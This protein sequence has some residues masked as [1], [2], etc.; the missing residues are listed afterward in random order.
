[1]TRRSGVAEVGLLAAAVLEGDLAAERG[2]QAEDDENLGA[3]I[4]GAPN[5]RRI[6]RPVLVDAHLHDTRDEA[7]EKSDV[8]V[9]APKECVMYLD[10][11][12]YSA[13]RQR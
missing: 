10:S 2:R 13:S 11:A 1:M 7:A 8:I 9:P 4:D 5:M 12:Y 3:A 6:D